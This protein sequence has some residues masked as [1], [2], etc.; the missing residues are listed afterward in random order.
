MVKIGLRLSKSLLVLFCAFVLN[1]CGIRSLIRNPYFDRTAPT[2]P[3]L[4]SWS[5]TSPFNQNTLM[6]NWAPSLSTDLI[7]Q[8]IQF[9]SDATCTVKMGALTVL[10][11]KTTSTQPLVTSTDGMYAYRIHSYDKKGNEGVSP[12]ST[13]M[14]VDTIPPT[15]AISVPANNSFISITGDS[16][17]YKVSG[18][19]S[20]EGRTVVIKSDGISIGTATCLSG[21]FDSSIP[22]LSNMPVNSQ[23]LTEAA[24]VF[25]AE[26]SD[27]ATNSTTSS[28]V[29]V[30][31]DVTAPNETTVLTWVQNSPSNHASVTAT[32][33][34]SSSTDTASQLIQ[35]YTGSCS[36]ESG[37]PIYL[38]SSAN[39][40]AF[41]G[42]DGLT[43]S[44]RVT[45]VDLAGN[46]TTSAC[47]S[48]MVIDT[49][50][51]S[52]S[53]TTAAPYIN[54]ANKSN[55]AVSG[56]CGDSGTGLNGN[57]TVTLSDGVNTKS[58]SSSCNAGSF[59]VLFN[60]VSV[61]ALVEGNNHITATAT[62]TDFA[63]NT[64]SAT[65][66]NRSKDIVAPSLEITSSPT[67][68]NIANI[69][70]YT[71]SGTCIDATSG[72]NGNIN[73]TMTDS[74]TPTANS[75]SQWVVCTNAG[76]FTATFNTST[77]VDGSNN[78]TITASATDF[79]GN[80]TSVS[81]TRSK[82]TVAPTLPIKFTSN[83][84]TWEDKNTSAGSISTTLTV[85]DCSDISKVLISSSATNPVV[86]AASWQ[87]C[88]TS[89]GGY[90]ISV[91]SPVEG[92]A[93][94]FYAW[95]K[96]SADN[97]SVASVPL[98]LTYDTTSP[99]VNSLVINNGETV[100]GN[101]NTLAAISAS[102]NRSDIWAFC[103]KYNDTTVPTLSS[104]CWTTTNT[105]I[106]SLVTQNLSLTGT[107][108]YP[109]RLGTIL[110]SYAVRLWVRDA[111]GN[112]SSMSSSGN[113][114]DQ[115]DLYTIQYNPDP[116]PVISNAIVSNT[117]SPTFPLNSA[118]TTAAVGTNIFIRWNVTDD[119]AFPTG[120][121]KLEYTTDES[122][123]TTIATGLNAT[124]SNG[125]SCTVDA[126]STGCFRWTT[127]GSPLATFYK[128]RIS[129]TDS[130]VS[131]VVTHTNAL[132][133]G[134]IN[135]LTG[136]TSLGIDGSANSAIFVGKN[137]SVY[138]D[139][140]DN[141]S[142]AVTKT[143]IIFF[144]FNNTVKYN[145]G[146]GYDLV[147][148]DPA[149][150]ILKTLM[151]YSGTASADGDAQ[152]G[153]LQS[154]SRIAL[155]FRGNLLFWDNGKIRRVD[156]SSTPWQVKTLANIGITRNE[157]PLFS[158]APNGRIYYEQG[159][160]I[161]YLKPTDSTWQSFTVETALS[162]TGLGAQVNSHVSAADAALYDTVACPGHR[163]YGMA[164]DKANTDPN[165]SG[166]TK[167]IRGAGSVYSR[168][169]C[170]N[171][172]APYFNSGMVSNFNATTGVAEAPHPPLLNWSD[173]TYTGMDGKIYVLRQG[174][175]AIDVYNPSN[176][177][178]ER[179][180]GNGTN[181]RCADGTASNSCPIIAMSIFV[182]EYGT[183]F[184]NDM[185]VIR[186][187][188]KD[189]K[190]QTLAGQP[191]DFGVGQ[192]PLSAR[193]SM[194]NV[195]D[196]DTPTQDLYVSN[197]LERKLLKFNL[198]GGDNVSLVA[199][200]GSGT[201]PLNGDVATVKDIS[202]TNG[203]ST[204]TAFKIDS[205]L[206]RL[207][208]IS[209]FQLD[210]ISYIDLSTGKWVVE[211]SPAS[212][213]N[214]SVRIGYVGIDPSGKLLL[215]TQSH[216][217]TQNITAFR[218][219]APGNSTAPLFY[220]KGTYV[221]STST[222]INS[223]ICAL[224]SPAILATDCEMSVD[225]SGSYQTQISFSSTYGWIMLYRN[226]KNF[227]YVGAD[228]YINRFTDTANA[229]RSYDYRLNGSNHTIYYCGTNGNLYKKTFTALGDGTTGTEV[230]L[231]LPTT[232]MKC[233]GNA[234]LYNSARNSVI[235][236]Y[237]QNG[238]YGL[239][240]Y[241]NP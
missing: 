225:L 224:Q 117:D 220:G 206:R 231:S 42:T 74:V 146:N 47:S 125:T 34:V 138:N 222:N 48:P 216:G 100:T 58:G 152:G 14:T 32:W 1:A 52:I 89:S 174:R 38:T 20:E 168:S 57:V 60:T 37:A 218:T 9:Y 130:G 83:Q 172:T 240:E 99:T 158:S 157:Y 239:A 236:I 171:I 160:Q 183:L 126:Y 188:D 167:L 108:R 107:G 191:R 144:K 78:I 212:V 77:L 229:V 118:Q 219:W 207:Y 112:I 210:R 132:N 113:G 23:N 149:T 19:C 192:N 150:G 64:T 63:G 70:I 159:N 71:V 29:N 93:N 145:N 203:W 237:N 161:K 114:T 2:S 187:K 106:G 92:Q 190:V 156:L 21:S 197:R 16:T 39:T 79:A 7:S 131:T 54:F 4:L 18:T 234:M 90:S 30:T 31:R 84:Y 111:A 140:H 120:P 10:P 128:I 97:I 208:H 11:S 181:G 151:K 176:N 56:T 230:Q 186:F 163:F 204:S 102:S 22:D 170:G 91:S 155:D 25:T 202:T 189:G 88:A 24:H 198:S 103:L 184:F 65:Q 129:A 195:F 232:D 49:T 116:P 87:N 169:D 226:S 68:V 227:T 217:G 148:V 201:Y 164:F 119:K 8:K 235:F 238:L 73:V 223:T 80:S 139:Y 136:N 214:S 67:W 72:I 96:D 200:N 75:V 55:Y 228:G 98:T 182:D 199:G 82:D 135:F 17:N 15:I 59:I 61:P 33:A 173:T 121:I 5:Q 141:G 109:Y 115:K 179:V 177:S 6:A 36:I 101:N 3:S 28:A 175:Y 86:S 215:N 211:S 196:V 165:A 53:I 50:P 45:T 110:N 62:V 95:A 12:C 194:I 26:I 85:S 143:G 124:G 153:T 137:E 44:Y 40:Q 69:T 104:T 162:L 51:P 41:T 66:A 13:P 94:L 154:L 147:F 127:P 76:S 209:S 134:G 166:F 213:Q 27:L 46:S 178:F 221:L 193:Y 233:D 43:Y 122:A 205:N 133:T 81:I 241:V 185:G 105:T 180:L 123:Y 35:F 142:L